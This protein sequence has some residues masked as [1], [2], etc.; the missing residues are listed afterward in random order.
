MHLLQLENILFH[1]ENMTLKL[2]DF[3]LCLNLREERPVTRAG[4]LDYMV[5]MEKGFHF[6]ELSQNPTPLPSTQLQQAPEILRCPVKHLPDDNKDRTDLAYSTAVGMKVSLP[7]HI[8]Y[9]IQASYVHVHIAHTGIL[10]SPY[11]LLV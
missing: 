8:N 11:E 7:I 1:G 6:S 9:H 5:R 3:G 10:I 4:T 2:A